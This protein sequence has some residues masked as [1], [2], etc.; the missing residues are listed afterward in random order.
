[1][2]S[3][4]KKRLFIII[5][6]T[7]M[8]SSKL[9]SS[10]QIV[11]MREMKRN[12]WFRAQFALTFRSE[13]HRKKEKFNSATNKLKRHMTVPTLFSRFCIKVKPEAFILVFFSPILLCLVVNTWLVVN[14]TWFICCS[15]SFCLRQFFSISI[16]YQFFRKCDF[17][18]EVV[19]KAFKI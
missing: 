19:C 9:F 12:N 1:M 17:L 5:S 6:G 16:F 8:K 11:N 3:L 4:R 18:L 7:R 15:L 13:D 2:K 10:F 14:G